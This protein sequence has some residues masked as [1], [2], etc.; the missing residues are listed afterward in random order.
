M[1]DYIDITS[2]V[3][4]FDGSMNGYNFVLPSGKEIEK[5]V[6]ESLYE[7]SKQFGAI[8]YNTKNKRNI[9][10]LKDNEATQSINTFNLN[11]I[12]K[13]LNYLG[14]RLPMWRYPFPTDPGY[15][16]PWL[17]D[18]WDSLY[19]REFVKEPFIDPYET[20]NCSEFG[21]D[22]IDPESYYDVYSNCRKNQNWDLGL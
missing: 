1:S 20:L 21:I 2:H 15:W 18:T 8:V 6:F 13:E 3:P 22:R 4:F 12:R 11:T 14:Q 10:S 16:L 17:K 9:E 7:L 19:Y 5:E